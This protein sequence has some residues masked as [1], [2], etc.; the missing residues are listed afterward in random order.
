M[1]FMLKKFLVVVLELKTKGRPKEGEVQINY[2]LD[3]L[4]AFCIAI[5]YATFVEYTMHRL[6]HARVVFGD[7][8][9]AHHREGT[10]NC[11]LEE[12]LNYSIPALSVV[13]FGFLYSIAAGI[14]FMIGGFLAAAWAA[15]A[16]QLQH[17]HPELT[18][19]LPR[20]IHYLHHKHKMWNYNFGISV[21][22]WDR[23]FGTYKAADWVPSGTPSSYPLTS[24]LQIQWLNRAPDLS[25]V[26]AP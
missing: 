17:E 22:F 15:Y 11:W 21:D 4:V 13:W 20:P 3:G 8:H 2:W 1:G 10:G 19:W 25:D 26:D 14:G 24:F 9:L 12:F 18:F 6:M 16:H 7:Q 5:V 23:V